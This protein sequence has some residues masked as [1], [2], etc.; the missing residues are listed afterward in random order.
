MLLHGRDDAQDDGDAYIRDAFQK[1]DEASG[2]VFAIGRESRERYCAYHDGNSIIGILQPHHKQ[3]GNDHLK[4]SAFDIKAA[5]KY[6]IQ[7]G[8]GYNEY[9][10]DDS[11]E[12]SF[13]VVCFHG[14]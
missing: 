9:C 1:I 5:G 10:Y 6:G 7:D 13:F 3:C 8:L 4:Q 14:I 11:Y 2:K 12:L